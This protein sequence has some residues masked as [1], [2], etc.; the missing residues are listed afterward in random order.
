MAFAPSTR[1][2]VAVATSA[3]VLALYSGCGEQSSERRGGEAIPDLANVPSV[4][5]NAGAGGD[6]TDAAGAS[7]VPGAAR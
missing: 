5:P 6:M 1:T 7:G 3:A 2:L 4:V